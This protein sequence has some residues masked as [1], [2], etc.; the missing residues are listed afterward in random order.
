MTADMK[1]HYTSGEVNSKVQREA[2]AA[3]RRKSVRNIG[4][5]P[6]IADIKRRQACSESVIVYGE[7]YFGE[8][9]WSL[10]GEHRNFLK[11]LQLIILNGGRALYVLPRGF[12]KTAWSR[13]AVLWAITYGHRFFTP[14]IS[15]NGT[16]AEVSY[17][18]IKAM[19]EMPKFASDFPEI[20]Y[21]ISRLE[22]ITHRCKGQT[23]TDRKGEVVSTNIGYDAKQIMTPSVEGAYDSLGI[24]HQNMARN[25]VVMSQ[26]LFAAVRGISVV[27]WDGKILRPDFALVDDPQDEESANSPAQIDKRFRVIQNSL[28]GS[29]G[30]EQTLAVAMAATVI[31]EDDL[32]E[33]LLANPA[34]SSQRVS[35]F[36]SLPEHLEVEWLGEYRRIRQDFDRED[37]D[38]IYRARAASTEYYKQNRKKMDK[39]ASV[40]WEECFSKPEGEISAIQHGMNALIDLG[41]DYFNAEL[42]NKPKKEV[43][44]SN[45]TI[46]NLKA[47]TNKVKRGVVPSWANT[48][49]GAV[50]VHDNILYYTVVAWDKDTFSGQVVDFG[51][52]PDQAHYHFLQRDIKRGIQQLYPKLSPEEALRKAIDK[53]MAALVKARY[54]AQDGSERRIDRMFYDSGY[55]MEIVFRSI[56]ESDHSRIVYP[57]KG[58]AYGAK[59]QEFNEV[60]RTRRKRAKS[61]IIDCGDCWRACRVDKY[62]DLQRVFY[63]ANYWKTFVKQ[64]LIAPTGAD[65]ALRICAYEREHDLFYDHMVAEKGIEVEAKGRKVEEWDNPSRRDNHWWDTLI[66]SA[67]AA[68]MEGCKIKGTELVKTDRNKRKRRKIGYERQR[69]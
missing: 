48:L 67:I 56:L 36:K 20:C 30:H 39:G 23:Y 27:R 8:G 34:W 52:Y 7:E 42:Q 49:T 64:R 63:D 41:E 11:R 38:D 24:F 58:E 1:T 13:I 19:L 16:L 45:L 3:A 68:S 55:K 18:A 61:D 37:P 53:T 62:K 43:S 10:S 9:F 14:L 25:S 22:G 35:M 33:Q 29:G 46:S 59:G 44:G 15:A 60:T 21:P 2:A 5:I 6:I 26:G 47:A 32:V 51:V 28:I 12:G 66:Y 57:S 17:N 50:D 65:G 69:S 54:K 4:E 40:V 31:Q